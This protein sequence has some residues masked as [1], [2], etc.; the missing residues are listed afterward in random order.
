MIDHTEPRE[1]I[2][3]TDNTET[4]LQMSQLAFYRLTIFILGPKQEF[5]TS[6]Q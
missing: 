3:S 2:D 6:I 1:H 5:F 4:A